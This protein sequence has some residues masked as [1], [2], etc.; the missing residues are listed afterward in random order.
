MNKI[1]KISPR[2]LA[3]LIATV[4]SGNVFAGD[5]DMMNDG[6]IMVVTP[7]RKRRLNSSRACPLSP[8]K[9]LKNHLR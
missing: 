4:L 3:L 8:L 1:T 5:D 9:I 2:P 6:E 7:L